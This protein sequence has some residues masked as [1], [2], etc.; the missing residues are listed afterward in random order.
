MPLLQKFDS[1]IVDWHYGIIQAVPP[2]QGMLYNSD[3]TCFGFW[4]LATKHLSTTAM[5]TM[6]VCLGIL[7]SREKFMWVERK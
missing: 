7:H 1:T 6:L 5:N 2:K 3:K 4:Q